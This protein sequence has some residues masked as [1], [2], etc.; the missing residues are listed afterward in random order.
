[1]VPIS[2]CSHQQHS[3]PMQCLLQWMLPKYKAMIIIIKVGGR[4]RILLQERQT[5]T[6]S[7][8][9]SPAIFSIHSRLIWKSLSPNR[10]KNNNNKSVALHTASNLQ[11][12]QSSSV[13]LQ[14]ASLSKVT[15]TNTMWNWE[16]IVLPWCT[17]IYRHH[18]V[19]KKSVLHTQL[20]ERN[21]LLV[22]SNSYT[23]VFPGWRFW[24]MQS[25]RWTQKSVLWRRDAV[26]ERIPLKS[27]LQHNTNK[28][29]AELQR[30]NLG[31]HCQG[32]HGLRNQA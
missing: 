17:C 7:S 21:C 23:I 31:F 29:L 8:P 25:L 11:P 30:N 3:K 10:T 16:Y 27:S 22:I 20:Q 6:K 32:G 14:K 18:T 24:V 1:M 12:S 15:F 2:L 26:G 5:L 9:T 19:E 4:K 13:P 28:L